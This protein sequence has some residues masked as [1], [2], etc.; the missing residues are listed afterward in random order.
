MLAKITQD[1][2]VFILAV[3]SGLIPAIFWLWFWL[4][5]EDKERPEPLGL[6][7][8]S[9]I[10]GALVVFPTMALEK[11]SL[12]FF[13]EN[14]DLKIV[15]WATIEE[16]LKF[17]AAFLIIYKNKYVDEPID[18]PMYFIAVA[19][20]F[21]ALENT[22]YLLGAFDSSGATVGLLT[23]NLRF[24]GSTLLHAIASSM[25]GSSLGMAFFLKK[26]KGR[27][28]WIGISGAIVLHSVFNLLIMREGGRNFLPVFGFLWVTTIINL[29]VFEK[30]K[31][32]GNYLP[33]LK[34]KST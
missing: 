21:A 25:I 19:L 11:Y 27:Y 32:M 6:I 16:L 13:R 2:K 9:F 7:V 23:G 10:V 22:L 17:L 4:R 34:E 28:L 24:L 31:R 18:F 8:L 33:V 26:R 3:L 1:P 15:I 29:L 30:L 12:F 14:S 5:N 20:G